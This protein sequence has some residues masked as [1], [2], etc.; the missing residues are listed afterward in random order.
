[1]TIPANRIVNIIPGV[2]GATGN[3]LALNGLMLTNNWRVP[4]NTQAEF[5]DA[6]EMVNFFG[7][8]AIEAVWGGIYFNGFTGRTQI[9]TTLW[10]AQFPSTSVGA[11]LLGGPFDTLTIPQVQGI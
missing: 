6:T 5:N 3:Q 8:P 2:E 9:P 1:M 11:W 4:I 7:A 10:V